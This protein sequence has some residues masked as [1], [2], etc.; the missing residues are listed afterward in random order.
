MI[1]SRNAALAAKTDLSMWPAFDYEGLSDREKEIIEN[2]ETAVRLLAGGM[3]YGKI[4]AATGLHRNQ[5]RKLA[6]TCLSLAP[7]GNIYG[8]RALKPF[9]RFGRNVRRAELGQKR[10]HQQGGMSGALSAT[11]A[12]FPDLEVM[13]VELVRKEARRQ[14]I[15]ESKI[16]G[17]DLHRIFTKE[18]K[19]RGLSMYD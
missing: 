14:L 19:A 4:A 5:I 7:D 9:A 11:L 1:W 6:K 12:R 17:T 3:T 8:F 10:Q 13:L 2:R 18:L 15:H 16:R